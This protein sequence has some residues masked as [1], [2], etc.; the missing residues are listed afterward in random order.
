MTKQSG[1]DKLAPDATRFAIGS[2][3]WRMNVFSGLCVATAAGA[4]ALIALLLGAGAV[5]ACLGALLFGWCSAVWN[6]GSH[7][8]PHAMSLMFVMLFGY[9][10]FYADQEKYG[11]ETDERIFKLISHGFSPV[12]KPGYGAHFPASIP[13]S[14]SAKDL[15][16]HLLHMDPLQRWSAVEALEE[17]LHYYNA[18]KA[19][20]GTFISLWHNQFLGTDPLYKGWKEIYETFLATIN[21]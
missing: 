6:K 17:M 8:D 2:V 16:S 15:I 1:F 12:T 13:C 21:A 10:P 5:E 18:C 19:V 9:P 3:A 7:V 11:A 20:N 14:D 4:T